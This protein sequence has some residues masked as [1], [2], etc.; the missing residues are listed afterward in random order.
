MNLNLIAKNIGTIIGKHSPIILTSTAA[1]G[2]VVTAVL[3]AKAAPH[4]TRDILDAESERTEP[5]TKIEKVRLTWQH[6]VPAAAVGGATIACI[7]GANTISTRRQAALMSAYTLTET[8]FQEYKAK[9]AEIHGE[10]KAQKIRDEVVQDRVAALPESTEVIITGD[11]KVLCYETISGRLFESDVESIRKA[12]NDIN[13]TMVHEM[14]ASLNDFYHLIGLP[15]TQLDLGWNLDKNLDISFT[16]VL[17]N[18][19]PCLAITY[20]NE[21]FAEYH[22]IW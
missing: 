17:H 14:S 21:P 3:A 13:Q 19:K 8:A 2:V 20:K 10:K 12:Q 1:A 5:L 9:T 7:I 15:A 18:N 22:K 6:Y 16:A 11:G 4:A